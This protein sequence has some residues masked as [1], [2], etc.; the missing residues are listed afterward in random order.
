[1]SHSVFGTSAEEDVK[2][3]R[4][5]S[6]MGCRLYG[7]STEGNEINPF[8]IKVGYS[9]VKDFEVVGICSDIGKTRSSTWREAEAVNRIV[10]TYGKCFAKLEHKVF[11]DNK[12]VKSIFG[13]RKKGI[14]EIAVDLNMYCDQNNITLFPEWIPIAKKNEK[15]DC[16]SRC[17]DTDNW[18]IKLCYVIEVDTPRGTL[19]ERLDRAGLHG[20]SRDDMVDRKAGY[21]VQSRADNTIKTKNSSFEHFN[22]R[23]AYISSHDSIDGSRKIS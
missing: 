14:H 6:E 1:M 11:S 16:L 8:C 20:L 22:H 15:S 4:L 3:M 2:D 7:T 5:L 17:F 19:K 23:H 18:Q 13:S 21:S 12:N 9:V 10:N